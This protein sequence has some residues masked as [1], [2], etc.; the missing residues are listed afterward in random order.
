L[1]ANANTAARK[2]ERLLANTKLADQFGV[3]FDA[4]QLVRPGSY[5]NCDHSDMNRLS[6]F[7][8]AIQTRKGRAI[9]CLIDTTYSDRLPGLGSQRS[10]PRTDALRRARAT[11]RLWQSFTDHY[12]D[13]LQDFADRLGFWPKLVFDRGFG[14]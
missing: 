10:T 8:G 7:A 1:V 3:V 5:V 6:L 9:P 4:L 13:A 2:S 12:V 14:H 11:A